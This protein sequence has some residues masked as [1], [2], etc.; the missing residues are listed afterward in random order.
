MTSPFD[1]KGKPSI[2]ANDVL[3]K[4]H[5]G[6]KSIE[7]IRR[8]SVQKVYDRGVNHGTIVGVN[9]KTEGGLSEEFKRI[10]RRKK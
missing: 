3:F 4:A 1:W 5:K 8:E 6:G 2:I 7:H 10:H 9:D